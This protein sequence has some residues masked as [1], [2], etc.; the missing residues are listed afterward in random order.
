MVL[1]HDLYK[2]SKSIFIKVVNDFKLRFS[3]FLLTTDI[4][5]LPFV[6]QISAPQGGYDFR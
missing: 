5:I 1:N 6:V 3:S 4:E 2:L